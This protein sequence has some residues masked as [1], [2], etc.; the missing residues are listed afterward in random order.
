MNSLKT[1]F[2]S[3]VLVAV[4]YGVYLAMNRGP[5]PGPPLE[6]AEAWNGSMQDGDMAGGGLNIEPGTQMRAPT[7][8][9]G[10]PGGAL[11][12]TVRPANAPSA[13]SVVPAPKMTMNFNIPDGGPDGPSTP[14]QAQ[15]S[16]SPV[17]GQDP[18]HSAVAD[19]QARIL[20]APQKSSLNPP[21]SYDAPP[22]GKTSF[23][24]LMKN[25]RGEL[26]RNRLLEAYR[27]LGSRYRDPLFTAD[28][29]AQIELLLDQLAGTIVYSTQH[30]IERPH[31]VGPN[32]TLEQIARS[33]NVPPQ[34][35]AKINGLDPSQPPRPGSQIKVVRGPFSAE[36]DLD[37][38]ELTLRLP[39][40]GDA[41]RFV[42]GVG[43]DVPQVEKSYRVYDKME[44]PSSAEVAPSPTGSPD[45][46]L[47]G[48]PAKQKWIGLEGRLGI[49]AADNPAE[50]GRDGGQGG[51][52]L[53]TRDVDDLYDI[54]SV[55]S[56]I[57][58]RR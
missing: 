27:I 49:H 56:Q 18:T 39:D 34:L 3:A 26:D 31:L 22:V 5:E 24:D 9:Q 7:V 29:N 58:I 2:V 38:H 14:K 36:V 48:P 21:S 41:G 11:P 42:V 28:E 53:R 6:V 15:A 43:R 16:A 30:F 52:T 19:N 54:L 47:S 46:S 4:L 51:I 20:A 23:A 33:Y 1:L 40:G 25:V 12:A 17:F 55:G 8:L 13:K 44:T 37:K 32:E 10:M 35:L 45:A 50:V 57:V